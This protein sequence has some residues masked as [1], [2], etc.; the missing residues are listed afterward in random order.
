MLKLPEQATPA[1]S[2]SAWF[3]KNAM[4]R[5]TIRNGTRVYVRKVTGEALHEWKK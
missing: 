2:V 5:R 3:I 1:G 4:I